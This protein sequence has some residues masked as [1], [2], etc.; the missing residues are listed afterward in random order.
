MANYTLILTKR[1]YAG[2][3]QN[4]D[5]VLTLTQTGHQP[6]TPTRL[7][8]GTRILVILG[9]NDPTPAIEQAKLLWNKPHL[10]PH[11]IDTLR[12][13]GYATDEKHRLHPGYL[14][15]TTY[16]LGTDPALRETLPPTTRDRPDPNLIAF[17]DQAFALNLPYTGILWDEITFTTPASAPGNAVQP[18]A[19]PAPSPDGPN[20]LPRHHRATHHTNGILISLAPSSYLNLATKPREATNQETRS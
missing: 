19:I 12:Q 1:G 7:Q 6:T 20:H 11:E 3:I 8:P 17:D 10:K 2:L 15:Y 9:S 16:R 4:T 14:P 5:A 13:A 18:E